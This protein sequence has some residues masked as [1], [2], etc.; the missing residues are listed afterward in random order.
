MKLQTAITNVG[1]L[2]FQRVTE[3]QVPRRNYPF[4]H[5]E[6]TWNRLR[7]SPIASIGTI[8]RIREVFGIVVAGLI[9]RA[10]VSKQFLSIVRPMPSHVVRC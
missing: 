5:P 10:K 1:N 4:W 6:V 8:N 7:G 3:T 9:M 2:R